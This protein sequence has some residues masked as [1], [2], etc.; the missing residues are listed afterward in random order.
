MPAMTS[1]R[2]VVLFVLSVVV[3]LM[4]DAPL[5]YIFSPEV[6]FQ[7]LMRGVT[8]EVIQLGLPRVGIV[9]LNLLMTLR[10]VRVMIFSVYVIF[11]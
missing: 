9:M 7:G 5:R 2:T 4:N 10:A 3:R 11:C 6:V 1:V 8:V